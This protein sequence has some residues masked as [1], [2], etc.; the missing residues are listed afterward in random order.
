MIESVIVNDID[1]V[2]SLAVPDGRA[3]YAFSDV[4]NLTIEYGAYQDQF[5]RNQ[6]NA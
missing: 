4:F 2:E 1:L 6:F 3:D 5:E